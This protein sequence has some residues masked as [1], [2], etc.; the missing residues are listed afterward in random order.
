MGKHES[1]SAVDGQGE[2]DPAKTKDAQEAGG[3]RHSAEDKGDEDGK[4]DDT[5]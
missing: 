3:G 5:K 1:K 2:L 4:D